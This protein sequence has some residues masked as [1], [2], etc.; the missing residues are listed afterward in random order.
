M[1]RLPPLVLLALLGLAPTLAACGDRGGGASGTDVAS[2]VGR[3]RYAPELLAADLETRHADEGP[4]VVAREREL[5]H[6]GQL[7]LEIRADGIYRLQSLWFDV[8]QRVAGHWRQE[9]K[10]LLF[11]PRKVDGESVESAPVEEARLEDGRIEIDFDR[12][13]FTLVRRQ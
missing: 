8:E 4:A 9:G 6:E 13:T 5:A 12:K 1:T 10:R 3:W 2:P 11:T 7:E